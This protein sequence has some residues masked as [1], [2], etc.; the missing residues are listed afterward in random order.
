MKVCQTEMTERNPDSPD[1]GIKCGKST[2]GEMT[3]R[4]P[5]S[6]DV[7]IKCGKSTFGEGTAALRGRGS[8]DST[9]RGR[10]GADSTLLGRGRADSTLRGRGRAGAVLAARSEDGVFP[11]LGGVDSDVGGRRGGIPILLTGNVSYLPGT[12]VFHR[13]VGD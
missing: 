5:D 8:A 2:F 12:I 6:L 4:N 10:G 7:G 9:L 11:S 1:V 3:E 13:R